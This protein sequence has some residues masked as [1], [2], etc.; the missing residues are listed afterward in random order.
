[1]VTKLPDTKLAG[2]IEKKIRRI[3]KF[4][5]LIVIENWLF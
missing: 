2:S 5:T 4:I 3:G 1:M